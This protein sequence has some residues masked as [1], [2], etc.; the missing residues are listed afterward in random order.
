MSAQL[1]LFEAPGLRVPEGFLFAE[2]FLA[3]A[4][5]R[6]LLAE[7]ERLPMAHARYKAWTARREVASFGGDYDF[8][9]N[10]LLPGAPLPSFLDGLR[11][12]AAGWAGLE[13]E[14]FEHAL[15]ARYTPGTPLGWHRDVP[16]FEL[17][18]GVSL[19]GPARMRLRPYTAE[20]EPCRR[21]DCLD[22]DLPPRS[23]YLLRGEARWA[24]QH[25]IAPTPGLRLSVTLRTRRRR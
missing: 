21:A 9:A 4:D 7:I 8:A 3:P 13:P 25:A 1:D 24:W 23:A 17:V 2:K 15:V 10:V 11:T 5:E 16:D 20:G 19:A 18:F 6:A 14:A 12:Q 22:V